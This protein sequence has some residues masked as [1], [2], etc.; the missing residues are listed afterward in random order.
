MGEDWSRYLRRV[1]KSSM[2]NNASKQSS[3]TSRP[4]EILGATGLENK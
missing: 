4:W 1:Y 2:E 3:V